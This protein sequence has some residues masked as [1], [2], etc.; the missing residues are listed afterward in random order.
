MHV[1]IL[2]GGFATRLWPSTERRAKPLLPLAGKPLLTHIVDGVPEGATITVSTNARFGD[3]MMNWSKTLDRP[4]TIVV[5]QT[6]SDD[7]KLGA[8]GA[9]AQWLNDAKIED[10]LLLLTGDNYFGFSM[11]QFLNETKTGLPTIA[12]YDI[13]DLAKASQFGV[14][15]IDPASKKVLSFEEKPSA[16]QSTLVST[17]CFFVPRSAL[18]VLKEHALKHPDNVGGLFE[19]MMHRGLEVRCFSFNEPWF[20]IGSFDAYLDAT[21]EIVGEKLIKDRT[22]HMDDV[23]LEGSVVVGPGCTIKGGTLRDTV[24]FADCTLT[25]CVLTDCVI[26]DHCVLTNVDLTKQMVREGTSITGKE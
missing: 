19:E 6:R 12:A 5:E 16:P 3:D 20:D 18:S 13:K 15:T 11:E 9:T 21:K 24:I 8:L 26:D 2:A 22:S 4:V 1:F 23:K 17:G 10:D 7:E 14:V 25:N